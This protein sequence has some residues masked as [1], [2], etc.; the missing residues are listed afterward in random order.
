MQLYF[1]LL[2]RDL[3]EIEKIKTMFWCLLVISYFL[4]NLQILW[5]YQ[6]L[7]KTSDKFYEHYM[8]H[9]SGERQCFQWKATLSV[10]F[11]YK[12]QASMRQVLNSDLNQRPNVLIWFFRLFDFRMK[13]IKNFIDIWQNESCYFDVNLSWSTAYTLYRPRIDYCQCSMFHPRFI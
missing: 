13:G 8:N 6:F 7:V 1:N 4:W 11:S 5:C 3:I 12:W 9:S 10:C 2:Y